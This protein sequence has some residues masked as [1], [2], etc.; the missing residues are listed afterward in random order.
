MLNQNEIKYEL[1]VLQYAYDALE[2]YI[3]AKTVEIHYTKHHNIYLS[4]LKSIDGIDL[5]QPIEKLLLTDNRKAVQNNGGGF[6]NHCLFW[7]MMG[8]N[9]GGKPKSCVLSAIEKEFTSFENFQIEFT[10]SALTQFGS[11]WVWLIKHQNGRLEIIQRSNQD[12]PI[13]PNAIILIGLDVWEHAYYLN[14]QNRRSD[15]IKAWWNVVDWDYVS[16][17]F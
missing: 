15:Y 4:N 9:K 7:Q 5:L 13:V 6:F 17:K 3:D 1:P 11:G 2:P 12:H 16:E 10:K 8:P 14:Y